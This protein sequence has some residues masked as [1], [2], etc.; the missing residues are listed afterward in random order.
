[1]TVYCRRGPGTLLAR[2]NDIHKVL[3][4]KEL[5][6]ELVV[7]NQGE[8]GLVLVDQMVLFDMNVSRPGDDQNILITGR[9]RLPFDLVCRRIPAAR[10]I[11]RLFEPCIPSFS[12]L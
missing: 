10:K 8:H 11:G 1:M 5:V 3:P 9:V 12:Y 4:G 2:G 7:A 6:H